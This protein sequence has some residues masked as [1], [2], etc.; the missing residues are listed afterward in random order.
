MFCDEC[1]ALLPDDAT[2]C[3]ACGAFVGVGPGDDPDMMTEPMPEPM[4]APRTHPSTRTHVRS[5][6][7]PVAP[8]QIRPPTPATQ[9]ARESTATRLKDGESRRGRHPSGNGH[10]SGAQG[11]T[12]G[13]PTRDDRREGGDGTLGWVCAIILF[14]IAAGFVGYILGTSGPKPSGQSQTVDGT[15][16]ASQSRQGS[17][18]GEGD[19]AQPTSKAKDE[20]DAEE[21]DKGTANGKSA[22]DDGTK[23]GDSAKGDDDG[24]EPGEA[25]GESAV[26]RRMRESVSIRMPL[27]PDGQLRIGLSVPRGGDDISERIEIEQDGK[28]VYGSRIVAP[29]E[30]LEWVPAEGVHEGPATARVYGI[31]GDRDYGT[32][33]TVDIE[34]VKTP[35]DGD[36]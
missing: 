12:S 10:A 36:E 18:Q 22:K 13:S 5:Q 8:T 1:G 3:D 4:P 14:V 16:D 9:V 30:T 11:S 33:V 24:K 28:I 35:D 15:V 21:G 25:D 29:A 26:T 20:D 6:A 19:A 23:D 32:P 7:E 27:R 2:F 31:L 17:E 34:I